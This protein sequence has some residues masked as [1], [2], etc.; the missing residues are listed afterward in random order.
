[1]TSKK[2]LT[3]AQLRSIR[4]DL[5]ERRQMLVND[6]RSKLN[7]VGGDLNQDGG[8]EVDKAYVSYEHAMAVDAAAREIHELQSI[9]EALERIASGTYGVCAEC[10]GAVALPRLQA[11]PFAE[12]CIQCQERLEEEG[13]LED[14]ANRRTMD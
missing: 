1:M 9:D 12:Y 14:V 11:L 8:D 10:G 7:E 13:V 6:S 4:T 3:T 2:G 5:L